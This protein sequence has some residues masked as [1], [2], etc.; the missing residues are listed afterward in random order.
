MQ[1]LSDHALAEVAQY[2]Q[3]LSEPTRLRI[4]NLLRQGEMNV[5]EITQQCGTSGANVSRHLSMLSK[6]GLVSRD[7]R[8]TAVYY[9]IADQEIYKLCDLVCGSIAR[10]ID[11][12]AKAFG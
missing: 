2:F 6:H 5:G 4:L 3:T 11:A 1:N 12:Q 10:R 8:G 7:V 9:S